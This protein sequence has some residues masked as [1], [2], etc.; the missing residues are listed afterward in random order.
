ME[1]RT[2]IPIFAHWAHHDQVS[3]TGVHIWSWGVDHFV[4]CADLLP[5]LN[6]AWT[7]NVLALSTLFCLNRDHLADTTDEMLVELGICINS[8][9]GFATLFW[10]HTAERSWVNLNWNILSKRLATGHNLF[11]FLILQ[12][13]KAICILLPIE[14]LVL[15][16]AALWRGR[17]NG[18]IICF[19]LS[20]WCRLDH[21]FLKSIY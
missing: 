7:V 5:L 9:F 15:V 21:I 6:T 3:F 17:T 19:C 2:R 1:S 4:I 13:E 18:K 16:T 11:N 10:D 12:D 20:R 14:K 8:F